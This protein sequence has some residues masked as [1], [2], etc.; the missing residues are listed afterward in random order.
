MHRLSTVPEAV[1]ISMMHP[2][3]AVSA[4]N[5]SVLDV[6]AYYELVAWPSKHPRTD[7]WLLSKQAGPQCWELGCHNLLSQFPPLSSTAGS[8]EP[9]SGARSARC[10]SRNE[11]AA[12]CNYHREMWIPPCPFS[13][14]PLDSQPSRFGKKNL[15]LIARVT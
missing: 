10:G 9:C 7:C 3:A 4:V 11:N 14:C 15:N 1:T 8:G 6:G 5:V 12:D 2:A 13:H